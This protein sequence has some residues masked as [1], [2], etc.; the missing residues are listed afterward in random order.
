LR[1]DKPDETQMLRR[2]SL[3]AVIT[4]RKY[5]RGLAK[6]YSRRCRGVCPK[7]KPH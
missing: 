5:L 2:T 3:D 7:T 4:T 1:A 6:K